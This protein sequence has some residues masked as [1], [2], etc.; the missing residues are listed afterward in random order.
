MLSRC[1]KYKK[2]VLIGNLMTIVFSPEPTKEY[3]SYCSRLLLSYSHRSEEKKLRLI[4]LP[5]LAF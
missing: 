3:A 1:E 4:F 2:A 5:A